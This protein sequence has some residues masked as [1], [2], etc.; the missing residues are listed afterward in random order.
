MTQEGDARWSNFFQI[1][2]TSFINALS[3][4]VMTTAIVLLLLPTLFGKRGIFT[5]SPLPWVFETLSFSLLSCYL[6][7]L[8]Y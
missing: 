2:V 7:R 3:L 1:P 6:P 8:P 5:R 4:T